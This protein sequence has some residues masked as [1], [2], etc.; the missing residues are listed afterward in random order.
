MNGLSSPASIDYALTFITERC[1]FKPFGLDFSFYLLGY[2]TTMRAW[3]QILL[4]VFI[5]FSSFSRAD[6]TGLTLQPR[7]QVNAPQV[8]FQDDT[9]RWLN[10]HKVVRVGIWGPSHPPI[11]EGMVRGIYQGIAADY[12]AILQDS[13][14]ITF[15]LHYYQNSTEARSALAHHEIQ[16]LAMWNP[17]RWPS[18]TTRASLPWLLDNP[19]LLK[20]KQEENTS[21]SLSHFSLGAMSDDILAVPLKKAYPGSILRSFPELDQAINA[22]AYS[23][24]NAL[25]INR[26]SASYLLHSRQIAGLEMVPDT[27][28]TNLNL[29]FGIDSSESQLLDA[30]NTALQQIPL[31]SRL[32]IGSG[33]GLDRGAIMMQNPLGMTVEE[34]QW[35]KGKKRIEV[36]LHSQRPP[37]SFVSPN[38]APEGLMIDVLNRLTR[39]YG[40]NFSLLSYQ[41]GS[42]RDALINTHPDALVLNDWVQ[43]EVSPTDFFTPVLSSAMVVIM[44]SDVPLP[45]NFYQL[46]GER[47]AIV[48]D[49]PL[50][51]TLETWYPTLRLSK[52]EN[53]YQAL[54]LLK[55]RSVRG[56][57]APQFVA[58]YMLSL[59]PYS[60]LRIAATVPTA[61]TELGFKAQAQGEIPL[62]IVDKALRGL[63]PDQLISLSIPW[64]QAEPEGIDRFSNKNLLSFLILAI[65]FITTLVASIFWIKS[66][67]RALQTGEQAQKDLSDQLN[68]TQTLIDN[69]PVAL[70]ARDLEGKL[71]RFNQG[72]A[73]TV[74]RDGA[75]Y[76]GKTLEQIDNVNRDALQ[77]LES[78]YQ[79]A[80]ETGESQQWSGPFTVDGQLHY[81]SGWTV[82]WRDRNGKICGLIG[83]WLDI[84]EQQAMIERIRQTKAALRQANA[85]KAAF[86]QS[87]GHEVRTPLNAII[88]L[89][90]MEIQQQQSAGNSSE[91]L[92][93]IWESACN[94]LSLIGDVFDV[95]RADDQQ[96]QG[97]VRSVNLPQLIHSTVALYRLQADE[98]H[99]HIEVDTALKTDHFDTDSLLIIRVFSSLL[100]NAIKHSTGKTIT[101]AL[102]QGRSEPGETRVPLVL[103][104]SNEGELLD[105]SQPDAET[106]APVWSETG[107]PL[108]VCQQLAT[109]H[110]G[111]I[112]LESDENGTVV[113][114]YFQAPPSSLTAAPISTPATE[115]INILIVDDY[116]PGRRALQQQLESWGHAV[117]IAE[118]GAQ[119]L[120]K[121]RN[122]HPTFDLII[123]DCT[124]P[125][126]DGFAMTEAIRAEELRNEQPP[127]PIFGLT[128]LTSFEATARCLSVG[129]SECLVKPLSPQALHTILQRHF[130]HLSLTQPENEQ[131]PLHSSLKEEMVKLH[132]QDAESL[133]MNLVQENRDEVSRLAHRISGSASLLRDTPFIDKCKQ[134]ENAC[135]TGMCWETIND[136]AQ[137]LFACMSQINAE[138]LEEIAVDNHSSAS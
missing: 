116:P 132:Q 13:L 133:K 76:T 47:M 19:V 8:K 73:E 74:K 64:R 16:M 18:H 127:V 77:R 106:T 120:N 75:M 78:Q 69:A 81:L 14:Q 118:D 111:E 80:L 125:V 42:E 102:F 55:N 138:L 72:W 53:L 113:S 137:Q 105:P 38:G 61:S 10:A 33:W 124:M 36:L 136:Y 1:C 31:A 65:L 44:Q 27:T 50:I 103:E 41:N 126:M 82:P 9:Q 25:W 51:S 88:G 62:Q 30:I 17:E 68:F 129:M 114:F 97:M 134:V 86:M 89:L 37:I 21:A 2:V 83:G 131:A 130:P 56:V 94:L 45:E 59:A 57:V 66:L 135:D 90:E 58:Q 7:I 52:S 112:A 85:S 84:T 3:I 49:N 34:E 79:N 6:S 104:V 70:Y 54:D 107:I 109:Q 63:T 5:I 110:G 71:L 96:L 46:K 115:G 123:T 108:S 12:L 39:E 119:G 100:R 92:P 4:V 29:S 121:W 11:G 43:G 101:V 48:G 35:L 128:A 23:Q 98:K 122:Q 32:R 117:F 20:R 28:L 93:L 40:L 22:V 91:N 99:V 95:F 67:R 87:M 26:I 60:G 24:I 15:E